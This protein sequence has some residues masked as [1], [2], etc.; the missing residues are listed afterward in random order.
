M[1]AV[2]D[3]MVSAIKTWHLKGGPEQPVAWLHHVARQRLIDQLRKQQRIVP[4]DDSEINGLSERP[5]LDLFFAACALKLTKLERVCLVL[6]V[7]GG[8]NSAEIARLLFESEES[9]QKRITRAKQKL[10]LDDVDPHDHEAKIETILLVLFAMFTAGY[11]TARG[12]RAT[13]PELCLHAFWLARDLAAAERNTH[14]ALEALLAMMCFHLGRWPARKGSDGLPKL[15]HEQERERDDP[16][17]IAEGFR[18]LEL[19]QAGSRITRYHLEAG[20]AAAIA[21]SA[22]SDELLYWH[23]AL[24][25]DYPSPM[26]DLSYALACGHHYGWERGLA[27]L[28]RIG[29][30]EALKQS[31]HY[32][33]AMGVALAKLGQNSE[34]A[35]W[36][37]KAISKEMSTPTRAVFERIII[38]LE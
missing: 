9:V 30:D 10:D 36:Y 1:D 21:R 37:R 24:R 4:L 5:E 34:A 31:P 12:D 16:V 19:A 7:C 38:E 3:A 15:L 11:D 8:L 26:A 28:Q 32:M 6:R 17:W 14:P 2:Q 35:T 33:G 13:H 29:E 18:H 22:P 27:E 23:D 25:Q 20:L